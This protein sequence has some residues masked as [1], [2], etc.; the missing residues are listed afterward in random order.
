MITLRNVI[1]FKAAEHEQNCKRLKLCFTSGTAVRLLILQA[2]HLACQLLFFCF[3]LET[4]DLCV[5][6]VGMHAKT[7]AALLSLR[8]TRD[9]ID[10]RDT[11]LLSHLGRGADLYT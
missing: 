2:E 7:L 6:I 10:R 9:P 5:S 1:F 4:S 11:R 3:F 8:L